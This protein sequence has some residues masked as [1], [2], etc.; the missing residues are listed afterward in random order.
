LATVIE[1][2]G[3]NA[4]PAAIGFT[5]VQRRQPTTTNAAG[6]A[7]VASQRV[8]LYKTTPPSS[9]PPTAQQ[10]PVNRPLLYISKNAVPNTT[11]AGPAPGT[12]V[13]QPGQ[14]PR[15]MVFPSAP[16]QDVVLDVEKQAGMNPWVVGG[17]IIGAGLL[18]VL[19]TSRSEDR[20]EA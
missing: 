15:D 19:F 10:D 20:E 4:R 6:Q 7:T 17:M 16:N 2:V 8:M 5:R 14:D 1:G 18:F 9:L 12:V 11:T 13:E 3:L